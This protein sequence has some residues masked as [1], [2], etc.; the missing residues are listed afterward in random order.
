VI[1]LFLLY[2]K[3]EMADLSGEQKRRLRRA[4]DE[5]KPEFKA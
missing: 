1:F 2:T 5:I 4:V 3:G